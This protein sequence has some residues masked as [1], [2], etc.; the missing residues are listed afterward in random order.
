MR[1]LMLF[2]LGLL[3]FSAQAQESGSNWINFLLG[4]GDKMIPEETLTTLAEAKN[5]NLPSSVDGVNFDVPLTYV[6]RGYNVKAGGWHAVPEGEIAGTSRPVIDFITI[7]GLMPDLAPV[8]EKNLAEFEKLGHG[9]KVVA[10][11][12]N[13]WSWDYYFKNTFPRNERRPESP[14]VPGMLYYYDPMAMADLYFSHD[15]P[16]DEL[17]Q[18]SCNDQN[19]FHDVSPACEVITFYRPSPELISKTHK[20]GTIFR[21]EYDFSSQYLPQ[22]REIDKK[23]KSLFDQFIRNAN[24]RMSIKKKG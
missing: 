9:E 13:I 6:F 2:I 4:L 10:S 21:L 15:Y 7:Y 22:W 20:Q 1:M 14:E 24:N 12:S 5:I 16:T 3:A 17:T 23:L 11:L 18:I 19:F 8:N